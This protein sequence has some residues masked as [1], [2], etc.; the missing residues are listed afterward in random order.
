MIE[1]VGTPRVPAPQSFFSPF[2]MISSASPENLGAD[3]KPRIRRKS[4]DQPQK[5]RI[6]WK[7]SEPPPDGEREAKE[8]Q[9]KQEREEKRFRENRRMDVERGPGAFRRSPRAKTLS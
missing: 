5:P 2:P 4:S 9:E 7:T 6:R 3:G 8:L 1:Q